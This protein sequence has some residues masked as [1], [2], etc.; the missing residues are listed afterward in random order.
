MLYYFTVPGCGCYVGVGTC[1]GS[2]PVT[3]R[4]YFSVGKGRGPGTGQLDQAIYGWGCRLSR[5]RPL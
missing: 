3:G 4:V 2:S 5:R 1:V